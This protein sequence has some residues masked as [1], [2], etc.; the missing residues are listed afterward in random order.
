MEERW[1]KHEQTLNPNLLI[2]LAEE[3]RGCPRGRSAAC[4]HQ[5]ATAMSVRS[6]TS[7]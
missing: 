3:P 4:W 1:N 6:F 7:L 2:K 5:S